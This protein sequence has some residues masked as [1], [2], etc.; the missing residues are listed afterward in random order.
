MHISTAWYCCLWPVCPFCATCAVVVVLR[1]V[2][3]AAKCL[4][5]MVTAN[6]M[7][8]SSVLAAN[9]LVG[10]SAFPARDGDILS[11]GFKRVRWRTCYSSS[12]LRHPHCWRQTLP[13]AE[14]LF[15]PGSETSSLLAA[16]ASVS[17]TRFKVF[18]T[19]GTS[20]DAADG[21]GFGG[22]V[23]PSPKNSN[24]QNFFEK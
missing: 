20:E 11:V 17:R 19:L 23:T 7:E 16:N 15:Q 13:L 21:F 3:V 9:A 2:I 10:R 12:G 4:L 5:Y 22:V 14:V 18:R 6:R 8:T 1:A 24:P